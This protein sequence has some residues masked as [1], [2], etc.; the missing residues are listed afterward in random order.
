MEE[1]TQTS[2]V[3]RLSRTTLG[4]TIKKEVKQALGIKHGDIIELKITKCFK[5]QD[6][7]KKIQI[8]GNINE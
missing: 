4:V 7:L 6:Q 1:I 8:G 2:K 5:L 3:R